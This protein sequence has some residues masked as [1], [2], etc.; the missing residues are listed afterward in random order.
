[1][2]ARYPALVGL[3]LILA[4]MPALRA[5]AAQG[6]PHAGHVAH[7]SSH[8][9]SNVLDYEVPDVE[10][11]D[12]NGKP[13]RFV[14]GIIG[15]RLA[16]VTFT[17]TQC[18]TVCPILD[19]IFKRLQNEI[20]DDLGL[21]TVLLSVSVDPVRDI[22]ERLQQHAQRLQAKPGWSFLTGDQQTVTGLLKAMEVYAPDLLDHPPTVFVVDG[23][24][25]VWT[26]LSGFPKP[27]KIV[28]VLERYRT[29]RSAAEGEAL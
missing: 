4:S 15:D 9:E 2:N 26:R 20:A 18:T 19:G 16:A 22:P 13:V 17:F 21:D 1:M 3:C 10:L 11:L 7:S 29:A 23:R 6:D 8:G 27:A 25:G 12:Q 14:S 24:S 28:E 5:Q